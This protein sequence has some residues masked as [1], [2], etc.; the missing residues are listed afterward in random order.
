[1]SNLAQVVKRRLCPSPPQEFRLCPSLPLAFHLSP[2]REEQ[3]DLDL[4]LR[5]LVVLNG[6]DLHLLAFN[7]LTEVNVL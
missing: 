1:M 4:R 3:D 2:G 7:A 5:G 6:L